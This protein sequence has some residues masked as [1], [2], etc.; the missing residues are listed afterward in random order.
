MHNL[1][2]ATLETQVTRAAYKSEARNDQVALKGVTPVERTL[3]T[4]RVR[5]SCRHQSALD[6]FGNKRAR[7]PQSSTLN[8][9][10]DPDAQDVDLW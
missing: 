7:E 2:A 4:S 5:T 3:T 6:P 9:S 8:G 1:R 10:C